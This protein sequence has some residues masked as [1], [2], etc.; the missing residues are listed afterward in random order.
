[1]RFRNTAQGELDFSICGTT[2]KV[3]VGGEVDIAPAH[4][5]YVTSRGIMLAA[6]TKKPAPKPEA[7][8]AEAPKPK[9]EAP[10]APKP[11]PDKQE[12]VK[13]TASKE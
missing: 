11:A 6:A 12:P 5:P 10:K 3:S 1:M 13:P 8:K 4:V 2:Y 7:P 9:P